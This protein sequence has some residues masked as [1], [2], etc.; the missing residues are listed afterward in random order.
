M[1]KSIDPKTRRVP[2]IHQVVEFRR[3]E[4]LREE[5]AFSILRTNQE[6]LKTLLATLRAEMDGLTLKLARERGK[7]SESAERAEQTAHAIQR[8]EW[9]LQ[10]EDEPSAS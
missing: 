3:R 4:E 9:A 5:P 2:K 8:L 7:E 6:S 10:R 1:L